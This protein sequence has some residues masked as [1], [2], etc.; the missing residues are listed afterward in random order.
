MSGRLQHTDPPGHVRPGSSTSSAEEV[1]RLEDP[2]DDGVRLSTPRV[3]F[4]SGLG[5][6]VAAVLAVGAILYMLLNHSV[7]NEQVRAQIEA[8]LT[9]IL[10]ADHSASIGETSVALGSGGLLSIDAS[11]V[12]IL[13]GGSTSL[14]VARELGVK[15]KPISLISGDVVAES[16]TMRGASIAIDAIFNQPAEEDLRP[17]WPRS[18]NVD[19]ALRD[20]GQFVSE[21]AVQIEGAG[22]ESINLEDATL[23]GFDQLGLRSRTATIEELSIEKPKGA[24]G[25]GDLDISAR[26]KTRF[27]TWQLNGN[28]TQLENGQRRLELQTDGMT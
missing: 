2:V 9:S 15:V 7:S 11:D 14:G 5:V 26:L 21:L 12:R 20:L 24:D 22:L 17:V 6:V 19:A 25:Q 23:V 13:Q 10:G 27:S 3:F 8:Q 16:V 1:H 18:L 4:Y 28:W